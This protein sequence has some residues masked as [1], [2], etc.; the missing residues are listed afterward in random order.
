MKP[1]V[2]I[3]RCPSCQTDFHVTTEELEIASGQVRCGNCLE[4]FYARDHMIVEQKSLFDQQVE[5]IEQ[6]ETEQTQDTPPP[7]SHT[8]SATTLTRTP[9]KPDI[10]R[11]DDDMREQPDAEYFVGSSSGHPAAKRH[12]NWFLWSLMSLALV[13]LIPLQLHY[14]QPPQ[15]AKYVWYPKFL[16]DSCALLGCE[17]RAIDNVQMIDVSGSIRSS[18]SSEILVAEAILT[19]NALISQP[20]PNLVLQFQNLQGRETASREFTPTEYAGTS[21][22][23]IAPDESIQLQ[24]DLVDPGPA[25]VNYEFWL[26]STKSDR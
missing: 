5:K 11:S 26:R 19:N 12:P 23:M 2:S 21:H 7:R 1:S 15:L 22:T 16:T 25:S 13:F 3:T 4:V 20:L 8:A 10:D 24:L 14:W 9:T 18:G 6:H 17:I